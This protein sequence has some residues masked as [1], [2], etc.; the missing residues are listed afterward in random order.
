MRALLVRLH[1]SVAFAAGLFLVVLGL[2]GSIMAFEEPLDV[3]LHPSLFRTR[4]SAS[5]QPLPLA[6][7]AAA[8]ARRFPGEVVRGFHLPGRPDASTV[9]VGPKGAVFLDG[10]TGEILG[11]RREPTFLDLVHQTH[12]RLV[13]GTRSET[14]RTLLLASAIGMVFLV[15]SGVVLWF[16]YR[17]LAVAFRATGIRFLLDLHNAVGIVSALFLLVLSLT[18]IVVAYDRPIAQS[19]HGRNGTRPTPRTARS[20]PVEGAAPIAAER[21]IEAA[22]A[23]LPGATPIVVQLPAAPADSY[24]VRLRFP[25]DRT[26]GGRSWV[27]VDAYSGKPLVVESSRATAFASRVI[28]LNRAIHT[29]DVLGLPSKVLVSFSSLLAVVQVASG[30]LL[31]LKRRRRPVVAFTSPG[32]V[33]RGAGA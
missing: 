2:T 33:S 10:R 18:G 11:T 8:V 14:G 27:A 22:R 24:D 23:A 13:P 26:P 6:D 28:T 30:L 4:S 1:L 12:L 17:Q 21:A 9:A 31:W 20:T 3:L 5:R 7:L 32:V 25:E 16:R 29:G 19:L 15:L